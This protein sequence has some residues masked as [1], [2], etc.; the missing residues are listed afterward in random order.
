MLLLR[1]WLSARTPS[2]LSGPSAAIRTLWWWKPARRLAEL[3]VAVALGAHRARWAQQ[4]PLRVPSRSISA[5]AQ[6]EVAVQAGQ[7]AGRARW[8][9]HRPALAGELRLSDSSIHVRSSTR[10]PKGCLDLGWQMRPLKLLLWPA[11]VGLLGAPKRLLHRFTGGCAGRL[12]GQRL[13]VPEQLPRGRLAALQAPQQRGH[14]G[15][16]ALLRRAV[17]AHASQLG[18]APQRVLD[19]IECLAPCMQQMLAWPTFPGEWSHPPH[20]WPRPGAAF[21]A[22]TCTSQGRPR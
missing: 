6:S 8:Q 7:Q 12:P 19:A 5:P 17:R 16:G 9:W 20:A 4:G 3:F 1:S 10:M 11:N 2:F 22:P 18:P 21:W 13:A 15:L 14:D